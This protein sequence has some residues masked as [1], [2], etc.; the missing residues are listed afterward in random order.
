MWE[1]DELLPLREILPGVDD[2]LLECLVDCYGSV[3]NTIGEINKPW[4]AIIENAWG[5]EIM[6]GFTKNELERNVDV[7]EDDVQHVFYNG[8]EKKWRTG[9]II[10]D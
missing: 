8:S 1:V 5:H 7:Q 6:T 4:L 2:D 9:L 3:E 10:E